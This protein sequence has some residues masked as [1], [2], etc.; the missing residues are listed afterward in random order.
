MI[1]S[2]TG[3]GSAKGS[4]GT[5]GLSVEIKSVNNRFL[6]CSV[7]I[8]RSYSFAEE[9]VKSAIQ[10][11]VG[12]GKL[13]VFVGIDSSA[14]EEVTVRL[15]EGVL[16][17]YMEVF[18]LMNTKYGLKNDASAMSYSRLPDVLTVEKK[19]PDT[20]KFIADLTDT[21]NRAVECFLDMR[22]AEG[23]KLA[24]D[25]CAKLDEMERLRSKIAVLSPKSVEEYRKRLLT[26][27]QEVIGSTGADEARIVTEA[28]IFADKTDV[29]EELVRLASHISQIRKLI[30]DGGSVGRKLDFLVQ[31][32]NREANTIGS[33]CSDIEITRMVVELKSEIEKIR[34][35]A[36]NIE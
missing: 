29:D 35:Q 1:N 8:P 36:Q 15:N 32:L 4:S 23:E 9:C 31:E 2:M 17:G 18:E 21:V 33:K 26:R 19:E 20:E 14:E 30:S 25:I 7:K 11:R 3:F 34:E 10:A 28:A 6:D 5:L 12:R 16:R 27:M 22:A 24:A 13:E